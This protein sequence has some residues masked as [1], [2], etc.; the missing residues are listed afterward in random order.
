MF[1]LSIFFSFRVLINSISRRKNQCE[2][3]N[4]HAKNPNEILKYFDTSEDGLSEGQV[5]KL[6][7]KHGYNGKKLNYCLKFF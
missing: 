3:E 5:E 7:E 6:R 2:M 4:A 1:F